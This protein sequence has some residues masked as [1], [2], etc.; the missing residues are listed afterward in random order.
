VGGVAAEAP[1]ATY[2]DLLRR[3]SVARLLL[4][5]VVGRLP[6]SMTA[7]AVTLAL[8]PRGLGFRFIGIAVAVLTVA[9]AAGGPVLSRLVDRRGQTGVLAASA[10]VS[11]AGLLLVAAAPGVGAAVLVGTALTGAAVPPLEPCLRALWP[12]L[13][14]DEN[15]PRAYSLDSV[16]Q[17]LVFV[18]GPLLV[19]VV[20]AAGSPIGAL[21]LT[22]LLCLAGTAVVATAEPS[23]RYRG[24]AATVGWL[25]P[26]HSRPL[27]VLL[28]GMTGVAVPVGGLGI[29]LVAYTEQHR[30]WG[31]A[32][33]LLGV[34]AGGA[35]AGALTYGAVRWTGSPTTRLVVLSAGLAAAYLLVATPATPWLMAVLC[36]VAGVFLPPLLVISFG[37]IDELAPPGTIVEAFGWLVT[38]FMVGSGVGSA[39]AGAVRDAVGTGPAA[40]STAALGFLGTA[41][42]ALFH[43]VH[44]RR[45]DSTA[46]VRSAAR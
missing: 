44:G 35:L 20:V 16:A 43:A 33:V 7:I 11:A 34:S 3:P 29:V 23:R 4:G 2:L 14:G 27:V 19:A 40:A 28:A 42:L 39:V 6:T 45:A 13:V 38:F 37:L 15:L 17:E 31:G 1:A 36:F 25:G 22:G 8:R 30:V 41:T 10:V 24:T 26:L 46:V 5:A 12:G 32:G 9:Q 18:I 21:V